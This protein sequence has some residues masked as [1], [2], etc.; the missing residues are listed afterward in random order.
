ML[1]GIGMDNAEDI[2]QYPVL[3]QQLVPV[4]DLPVGGFVAFGYAVSIVDFLRAVQT[5]TDGEALHRKKPA[6]VLIEQDTICLQAIYDA[7]VTGP[8]FSL[9]LH[10]LFKVVLPQEQRLPAMPRK[11]NRLTGGGIYVLDNVLLEEVVGH[12]ERLALGIEVLLFQIV[13][14]L[15]VQIAARAGGLDKHLKIPG[16]FGH[17]SSSSLER[18]LFREGSIGK[19]SL[20]VNENS[21]DM[22]TAWKGQPLS[23]STI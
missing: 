1:N 2:T 8:M 3:S 16:S 9:Q 11:G 6:P 15:T 23:A 22:K 17:G 13:A 21:L 19:R 5:E 7:L 18:R 14:I 4:H 12:A 10:D 20:G